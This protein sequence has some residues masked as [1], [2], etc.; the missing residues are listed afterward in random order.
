MIGVTV[1]VFLCLSMFGLAAMD[2]VTI[3]G[4]FNEAQKAFAQVFEKIV[5]FEQHQRGMGG[6]ITDMPLRLLIT[7]SGAGG[8]IGKRGAGIRALRER[9]GIEARVASMADFSYGVSSSYPLVAAPL[10]H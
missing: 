2:Q 3:T 9:L 8:V 7:N 1:V 10:C 4:P 6:P 5:D